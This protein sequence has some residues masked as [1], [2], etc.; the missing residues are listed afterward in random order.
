MSVFN[1]SDIQQ[2]CETNNMVSPFI[3]ENLQPASI[4][5]TLAPTLKWFK[6]QDWNDHNV[7][8]LNIREGEY[9]NG[10]DRFEGEIITTGTEINDH[11]ILPP[12]AFALASTVET[13]KIPLDVQAQVAGKSSLARLGLAVHVTAGF[14]DPAFNGQITL[15]LKNMNNVH[16]IVLYP[17]MVIA[18]VSFMTLTEPAVHPYDGHYQNQVGTTESRFI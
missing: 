15:E 3:P 2:E 18:Q 5:V 16:G 9:E 8:P 4:D 12:N 17:N 14:I 10:D 13:F 7:P 11:Y 6:R 1:D